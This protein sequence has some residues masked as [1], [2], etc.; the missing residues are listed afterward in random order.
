MLTNV[1]QFQSWDARSLLSL[2]I[3]TY[4]CILL[5]YSVNEDL[6]IRNGHSSANRKLLGFWGKL[7]GLK[8]RPRQPQKKLDKSRILKESNNKKTP[9]N[10][11]ELLKLKKFRRA[12]A[13]HET[14]D[15]K[16]KN[17]KSKSILKKKTTNV[18]S[19]RKVVKFV[20]SEVC[21]A[22]IKTKPEKRGKS[23][24]VS[25]TVSDQPS[26]K[27]KA[28]STL[29][30]ETNV[31]TLDVIWEIKQSSQHY[32]NTYWGKV[33]CTFDPRKGTIKIEGSFSLDG[34]D[35]M[36]KRNIKCSW[37]LNTQNT[38]Y[39]VKGLGREPAG[40]TVTGKWNAKVVKVQEKDLWHTVKNW[41]FSDC[42]P[43]KEKKCGYEYVTF[44]FSDP[45][46]SKYCKQPL[47]LHL[48]SDDAETKKWLHDIVRKWEFKKSRSGIETID[49]PGGRYNE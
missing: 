16:R 39:W 43:N 21:E 2:S 15:K 8:T 19:K 31:K 49:S 18:K 26:T 47:Y 10:T 46:N 38:K 34:I 23:T 35:Q 4:S 5:C 27:T 33:N 42:F 36:V 41:P 40:G 32:F 1:M 12:E 25:K 45:Q 37:D 14:N 30:T 11:T 9:Q 13:K 44:M 22:K 20:P 48:D 6:Q 7:L 28:L 29:L 24:S 17:S 3:M